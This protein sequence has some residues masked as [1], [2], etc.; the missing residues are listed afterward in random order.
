MNDK[1]HDRRHGKG[2]S[3]GGRFASSGRAKEVTPSD[4]LRLDDSQSPLLADGS[5]EV[6]V[7]PTIIAARDY[8]PS[9]VQENIY[10]VPIGDD[11]VTLSVDA[12]TE[13]A[14]NVIVDVP[15]GNG[16]LQCR[17]NI[18]QG[19]I[20]SLAYGGLESEDQ[21]LRLGADM[22]DGRL[23]Y[24]VNGEP[25]QGNV[26]VSTECDNAGRLVSLTAQA[27]DHIATVDV[28]NGQ[29]V[30]LTAENESKRVSIIKA[31]DDVALHT[32]DSDGAVGYEFERAKSPGEQGVLV[33][34]STEEDG[35]LGRIHEA[36]ERLKVRTKVDIE[37]ELFGG[38]EEAFWP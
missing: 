29:I 35:H 6:R 2:S 25:S 1:R 5:W 12:K 4:P 14:T 17:V 3:Q 33:G 20:S 38:D 37:Y 21:V 8:G 36:R 24:N 18:R 30:A 16:D 31:G 10:K 22:V 27:D 26:H 7:P 11:E 15:G 32:E 23:H 13:D 9:A 19:A 28:E 34:R